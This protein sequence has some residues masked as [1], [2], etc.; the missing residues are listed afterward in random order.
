[1][2][3]YRRTVTIDEMWEVY[4]TPIRNRHFRKKGS[5]HPPQQV[6]K[7]DLHVRKV[8][9]IIF[10]DVHGVVHREYLPNGQT[11]TA[12][13]YC[14]ILDRVQTALQEKRPGLFEEGRCK[15]ILQQDNATP[16]TA[17]ITKTKIRELGWEPM[18]HPPYSPDLAPSDFHLFRSLSNAL[19]GTKFT[20]N[21]EVQI[22]TDNFLQRKTLESEE[23]RLPFFRRGIMK[24]PGRWRAC[25]DALGE[26]FGDPE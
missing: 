8:M 10:W 3:F 21:E 4:E 1:M 24:L 16:H 19:R 13:K 17:R 26:Y 11:I 7:K 6:A 23:G 2:V 22:F 12:S 15:V 20:T 14:E 18:P 5:Q 25:I 9:L